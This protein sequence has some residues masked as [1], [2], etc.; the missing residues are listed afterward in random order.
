MNNF[1]WSCL[2]IQCA[3][4]N[5]STISAPLH[6]SVLPHIGYRYNT[7]YHLK[8]LNVEFDHH[9]I[10]TGFK[11]SFG[12]KSKRVVFEYIYSKSSADYL[13]T[14]IKLTGP[15]NLHIFAL[16]FDYCLSMGSFGFIAGTGLGKAYSKYK[17]TPRVVS[18]PVLPV[19]LGYGGDIN[20][21]G[22]YINFDTFINIKED[23]SMHLNLGR[24]LF[25][26]IRFNNI[27]FYLEYKLGL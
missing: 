3:L 2:L 10:S 9:G 23:Y 18:G 27:R 15:Y 8:A 17:I 25:E 1:M 19:W 7:S 6:F 4:F 11:S 5:A 12:S 22:Y 13:F 21:S 20:Y 14:N 16:G 26:K 24:Y